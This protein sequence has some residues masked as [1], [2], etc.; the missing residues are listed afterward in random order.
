[1]SAILNKILTFTEPFANTAARKESLANATESLK[2]SLDSKLASLKTDGLDV[3][4]TALIIG[5][6]VLAVYLLLEAV[7]PDEDENEEES[8][9][10]KSKS[11]TIVLKQAESSF[12]TKAVTGYAVTFLLGLAK[13]KLT[14]YLATHDQPH[15]TQEDTSS[16]A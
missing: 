7:L 9:I 13:Q 1:M 14:D 12:I 5:G 11:R 10:K 4:K 6:S 8:A 3:A 2:A 16:P 15:A